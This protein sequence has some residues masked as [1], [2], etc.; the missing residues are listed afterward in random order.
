MQIKDGEAESRA[1][2]PEKNF[3]SASLLPLISSI[4]F[5]MQQNSDG[6]ERQSDVFESF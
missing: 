5:V 6:N 3:S 4:G 2:V 1:R